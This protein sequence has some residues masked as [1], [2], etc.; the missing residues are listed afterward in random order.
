MPQ[1]DPDQ[2]VMS[3][4]P[5]RMFKQSLNKHMLISGQGPIVEIAANLGFHRV[6]TVDVFS[7]C[8]P[9]LDTC[10]HKRRKPAVSDTPNSNPD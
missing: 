1:I 4:S 6:T 5:L 9:G 3:H 2:V 10:D 7:Q 8:F